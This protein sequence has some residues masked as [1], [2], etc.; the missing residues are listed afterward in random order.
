MDSSVQ[1]FVAVLVL[2]LMS[3]LIAVAVPFM[4]IWSTLLARRVMMLAEETPMVLY[5]LFPVL[6]RS[7]LSTPKVP[8][9][10]LPS[11]VIALQVIASLKAA[12]PPTDMALITERVLA[13]T[14][15]LS[16]ES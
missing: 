14:P 11:A 9:V 13:E 6:K 10:R 16:I 8:I 1:V 4:V 2:E 5:K 7:R 15:K 3:V 12:V